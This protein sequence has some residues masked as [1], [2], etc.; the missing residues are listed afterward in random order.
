MTDYTVGPGGSLNSLDLLYFMFINVY[1][2]YPLQ[3]SPNYELKKEK[4][5]RS[6]SGTSLVQFVA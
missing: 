6:E 3:I 2:F 1:V 5:Y 4:L